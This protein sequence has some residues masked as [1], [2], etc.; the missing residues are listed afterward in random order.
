MNVENG[1]AP[2]VMPRFS[3]DSFIQD[4]VFEDTVTVTDGK[5]VFNN[6]VFKSGIYVCHEATVEVRGCNVRTA[7]GFGIREVK[8]VCVSCSSDMMYSDNNSRWFCPWCD[9]A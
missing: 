5:A 2:F 6:C 3:G 9:D 8:K 4:T 1:F 7:S